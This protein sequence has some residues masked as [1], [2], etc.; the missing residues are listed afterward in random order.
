MY[1]SHNTDNPNVLPCDRNNC[2]CGN[3]QN[4]MY[5]NNAENGHYNYVAINGSGDKNSPY[6]S[7]PSGAYDVFNQ[8]HVYEDGGLG[9]INGEP[10]LGAYNDMG[11]Y[12][13]VDVDKKGWYGP[14]PLSYV[15]KPTCS[16]YPNKAKMTPEAENHEGHYDKWDKYHKYHQ[17][18]LV[19]NTAPQQTYGFGPQHGALNLTPWAILSAVF[20]VLYYMHKT[21]KVTNQ[22]A[23][24]VAAVVLVLFFLQKLQ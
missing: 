3:D 9:G 5:Y 13:G 12:G 18:Q 1:A 4:C 23:L 16:G 8:E 7:C 21:G 6:Y 22:V 10:Q 20:A 24:I 19:N 14:A 17:M 2:R 15:D 11:E